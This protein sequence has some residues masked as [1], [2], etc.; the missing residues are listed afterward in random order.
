MVKS[1]SSVAQT[2]SNTLNTAKHF[3]RRSRRRQKANGKI[4]E[5][6][7]CTSSA[8]KYLLFSLPDKQL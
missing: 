3:D 7:R 4:P 2:L 1:N 6:P 5:Q 8:P